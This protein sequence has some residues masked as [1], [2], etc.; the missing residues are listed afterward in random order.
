M[1]WWGGEGVFG[2]ACK[3]LSQVLDREFNASVLC[4]V[5][6]RIIGGDCLGATKTNA[7]QSR[8]VDTGL[9]KVRDNCLGASLGQRLIVATGIVAVSMAFDAEPDCR[10]AESHGAGNAAECCDA[11]GRKCRLAGFETYL[12]RAD[13]CY[14]G[15]TDLGLTRW[16]FRSGRCSIGSALFAL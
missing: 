9:D 12:P 16:Y 11:I 15:L 10:V 8:G 2:Y 7:V 4:L 1:C 6:W 14:V 5:F 3:N 13:P